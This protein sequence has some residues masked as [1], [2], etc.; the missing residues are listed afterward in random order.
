MAV[1]KRSN[2]P[3][4]TVMP[5]LLYL[6]AQILCCS[7]LQGHSGVNP[8]SVVGDDGVNPRLFNLATLLSSIGSDAHCNAIVE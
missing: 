3:L 7:R 5:A 8:V 2:V 1:V 6:T 4:I